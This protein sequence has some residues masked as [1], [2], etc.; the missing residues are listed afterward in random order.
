MPVYSSKMY[1]RRL[2]EFNLRFICLLSMYGNFIRYYLFDHQSDVFSKFRFVM[3][4]P[5][6]ISDYENCTP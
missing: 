3:N 5:A 6:S 2:M 4:F 1:T